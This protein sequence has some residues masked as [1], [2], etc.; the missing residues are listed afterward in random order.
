MTMTLP[1]LTHVEHETLHDCEAQIERALADI[2]SAW[3]RIGAA[4]AR[5]HAQRLY[6]EFCDTFDEYV[7][8]RWS[9]PRS[10]AYEWIQAAGVVIAMERPTIIDGEMRVI[11][12]PARISHARELSRL[13][14][15]EM[16]TALHEA[17]QLAGTR[18]ASEPT[19]YEVR[20]VVTAR[21]GE[22]EPRSSAEQAHE[23]QQR[24]LCDLV[25][26]VWGQIDEER[27]SALLSELGEAC[28]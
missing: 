23:R 7:E 6:R 25:R 19:V 11:E 1:P 10:S 9:L 4:L 13:P 14:A 22:P 5:I 20:R 21:L 26:R 18:G 8:S 2:R 3:K 16:A 15:G 17:R 24:A 12:P 27:R 28:R